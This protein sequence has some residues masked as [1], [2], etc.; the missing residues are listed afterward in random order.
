MLAR[1]EREAACLPSSVPVR[2]LNA[3]EILEKQRLKVKSIGR[4]WYLGSTLRL[5][6]SY[7]HFTKRAIILLIEFHALNMT[8]T[9]NSLHT[10]PITTTTHIK[11]TSHVIPITQFKLSH[12]FY[13]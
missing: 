13:L 11:T 5:T 12:V 2:L 8:T 4:M 9:T 3:R 6:C 7:S 1:R 10:E